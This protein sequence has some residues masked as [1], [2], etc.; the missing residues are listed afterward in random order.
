MTAQQQRHNDLHKLIHLPSVIKTKSTMRIFSLIFPSYSIITSRGKCAFVFSSIVDPPRIL[1]S[2][3]QQICPVMFI[4]WWLHR[5]I[6]NNPTSEFSKRTREKW[7]RWKDEN[8]QTVHGLGP[9]EWPNAQRHKRLEVSSRVVA[10]FPLN[11]D[12]VTQWSK[13]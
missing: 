10:C 5:L 3:Q 7:Q 13:Y 11:L 9:P 6:N 12:H 4:G 2:H 1:L 8:E